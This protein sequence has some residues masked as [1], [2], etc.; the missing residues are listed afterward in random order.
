METPSLDIRDIVLAEKGESDEVGGDPREDGDEGVG[1]ASSAGSCRFEEGAPE[2]EWR[3]R[4]PGEWLWVPF[5][6][7]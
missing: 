7:S 3:R 6:V 1:T 5:V 2:W 4:W